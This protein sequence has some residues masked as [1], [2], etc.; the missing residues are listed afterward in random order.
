MGL[1]I[2]TA[3][4][5]P[6]KNNLLENSWMAEVKQEKTKSRQL[7]H[8]HYG[9][10]QIYPVVQ[11]LLTDSSSGNFSIAKLNDAGILFFK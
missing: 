4:D 2:S 7:T 5:K 3:I 10:N 9:V 6:N 1:Q 11:W 8:S